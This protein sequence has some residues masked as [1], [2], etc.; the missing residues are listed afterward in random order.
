MLLA[1]TTL[2]ALTLTSG[3][4]IAR[5]SDY[6][7]YVTATANPAQI[8]Q[9][10]ELTATLTDELDPAPPGTVIDFYDL[11]YS[12][13]PFGNIP[14]PL[15]AGVP[16]TVID[17]ETVVARCVVTFRDAGSHE[18]YAEVNNFS[19]TPSIFETVTAPVP[20]D[21]NQAALTGSW[22]NPATG[23]QGL[24]LA[25]YPA[26]DGSGTGFLFGGWFTFDDAGHPRWMTLQG[27]LSSTDGNAYDLHVYQSS[28]GVFAAP[29]IVEPIEGQAA[30]LTFY[31]CTH[32]TLQYGGGGL[33]PVRIPYVR[34]TQPSGCS[35]EVPAAPPELAPPDD[36]ALVSG[37]WYD[38]DTSGQGLVID[39]V[40]A[41]NTLF[42]AWYT[43]AP[44][45]VEAP[46]Q[47]DQRWFVMQAP[48]TP[49]TR[50]LADVPVVAVTGGTFNQPGGIVQQPVGTA[51][52]DFT[53][54]S[55]MTLDYSFTA[56][57]FAGLSGRIEEHNPAPA[58]GCE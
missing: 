35:S 9:T 25:V 57:E 46:G 45:G 52:L 37:S 22:Y 47:S 8:G 12:S 48:Y 42:A 21:A 18:L 53:S 32:A 43:F 4:Q 13:G 1:L 28:G 50:S 58:P 15:C 6:A 34:L 16:I 33:A 14:Y 49:G 54:C 11:F 55:T 29:P 31:D 10:V 5:A 30:T 3:W 36:D 38:P 19:G 2:F 56:G 41:Q 23:G 27:P 39:L 26:T 24:E 51:N 44:A 20:F 17:V 40:P 7:F